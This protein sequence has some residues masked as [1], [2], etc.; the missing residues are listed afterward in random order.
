MS[1]RGYVDVWIWV[2]NFRCT[3]RH[4][5]VELFVYRYLED[6]TGNLMKNK[7]VIEA[8]SGSRIFRG[9]SEEE[10]VDIIAKSKIR[11]YEKG[12]MVFSELDKP[13]DLLLLISGEL[14]VAKDTFNGKR[15][16]I[17]TIVEPG[18][19]FGEVYPFIGIPQY[20]MY[21]EAEKKSKVISVGVEIL[22]V[23]TKI[24]D[25]LLYIFAQKAYKMNRRL[26]IL[27]ASGIRGKVARFI[28]EQQE[29]KRK[30]GHKGQDALLG[31]LQADKGNDS[32]V[33]NR[34][35]MADYM[36]VTRPSLSREISAMADEGII[37][38]QGRMLRVL[39]QD[40]LEEY[41]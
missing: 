7:K 30:E 9:L 17:T 23:S 12:E 27:G 39:D 26:R 18:D 11:E 33:M 8:L 4:I 31:G 40:R 36:S 19:M 1:E 29:R 21:V 37:A 35:Q 5:R 41:L 3:G 38:V 2:F 25:N 6:E 14:T 16:I 28:V 13:E 22:N 32:L 10:I 34:E 20:D 15:L 24:R